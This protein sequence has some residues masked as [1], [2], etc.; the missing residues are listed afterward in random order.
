M[1]DVFFAL[2]VMCVIHTFSRPGK[3]MLLTHSS[4][5]KLTLCRDTQSDGETQHKRNPRQHE[6]CARS[7]QL[8]IFS[9]AASATGASFTSRQ[10]L[11]G[12]GQ[13]GEPARTA[14]AATVDHLAPENMAFKSQT[15]AKLRC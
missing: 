11:S 6:H 12:A 5:C 14:C 10:D 3:N 4:V 2:H 7:L 1:K 9:P 8:K 13:R 15:Q